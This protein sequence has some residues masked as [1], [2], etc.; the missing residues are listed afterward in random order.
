MSADLGGDLRMRFAE[1]SIAAFFPFL[2]KGFWINI[3]PCSILDVLCNS[4]ALSPEEITSRIQTLFLNGQPVD[5]IATAYVQDGDHLA[6]SA[7]MP[8]L[9]G[10]TMRAGGALA[11][12]RH[13]IS[14]HSRTAESHLREGRLTVK[15]FN[16][17]IRELGPRFLA[18]GILVT[19]DDLKN[20]MAT[21]S[22]RDWN[23]C[24]QALLDSRP[25]D[26][27]ALVAMDWSPGSAIFRLQ[28]TFE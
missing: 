23:D 10:A 28:V 21:F 11:G 1:R 19:G 24:R 13:S 17:L 14:H 9:V 20:L 15:L 7:A 5:D 3:I 16:L 12:L 25:I 27:D 18:R 22:V 8:G 26:A 2:Q 4:C 6:L